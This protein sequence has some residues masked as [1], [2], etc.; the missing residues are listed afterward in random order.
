MTTRVRRARRDDCPELTRIAHAAKAYW[1]YPAAWL[2][3]WDAELTL[4]PAALQTDL[5]ACATRETRIVG[6]YA[7]SGRGARRELEHLWV[8]PPHIGTGVG[9][10]L[11]R[12][13]LRRLQAAGVERVRIVSDPHAE[14][15]YRRLGARRVGRVASRP[16]GRT[17]QVYSVRVDAAAEKAG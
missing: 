15:F 9:T 10:V 4:T 16:A 1:G 3:L 6:F 2:Q 11:W 13:A 5:V 12:D 8:D 14:E 7:L 17:L